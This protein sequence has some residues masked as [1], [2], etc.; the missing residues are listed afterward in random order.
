[1]WTHQQT[2]SVARSLGRNFMPFSPWGRVRAF[3][4]AAAV[5]LPGFAAQDVMQQLRA[6]ALRINQTLPKVLD[7]ETRIERVTV[8][9]GAKLFY[10]FTINGPS[11]SEAVR[12]LSSGAWAADLKGRLCAAPEMRPLLRAG[13]SLGYIYREQ[14][15]AIVGSVHATPKD[16]GL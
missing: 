14:G 8:E 16:C 2:R 1:M 4:F 3:A 9:P 12:R 5:A 11:A 15:G 7:S 10:H 6:V 13:V